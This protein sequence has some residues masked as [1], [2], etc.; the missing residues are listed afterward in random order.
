M[1]ITLPL[2]LCSLAVSLA[3]AAEPPSTT[4]I[5][6]HPDHALPERLAQAVDSVN[7]GRTH[8]IAFGPGEFEI[9]RPLEF[10]LRFGHPGLRIHGAGPGLTRLVVRNA[11]AGIRAHLDTSIRRSKASPSLTIDNLS[12]LAADKCGTAIDLRRGDPD[13]RGGIAAKTIHNL[14]IEGRDGSWTT[15]IQADDLAFCTFRDL[16]MR[17]SG[18]SGTGIHLSGENSPVDHHIAG[19]RILG[20]TTGILV[21][22]TIE[23]V[24]INQTTMIGTDVGIHWNTSSHE[25]LLALSG[26]HINARTSCVR[27]NNLLQPIITGN[28][29]YQADS[30]TPWTGLAILP[31]KPT[32]YDL[33][34]ISNNTFH[35]DPKHTAANIGLDIHAASSGVISGNIFSALDTGIRLGKQAAD[36]APTGSVFK[37]T[38]TRIS[39]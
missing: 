17:F 13:H 27:A 5:T 25:P 2:T 12:L 21:T 31:E 20:G 9:Q 6:L 36:L 30:D 33:L 3:L 38:A 4:T 28:L 23:G 39:R 29:F 26:S 10:H 24:Y 7:A 35:G 16:T 22:G 32:S 14:M 11:D 19:L 8:V 15:G 34:Q 1:R 18:R 37:N